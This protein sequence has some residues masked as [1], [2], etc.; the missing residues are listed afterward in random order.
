MPQMVEMG[1]PGA[2]MQH[3]PQPQQLGRDPSMYA[4]NGS[5]QVYV[6]GG[7][8]N[9]FQSGDFDLASRPGRYMPAQPSYMPE[10]PSYM[11]PMPQ[12]PTYMPNGA[13]PGIAAGGY[14]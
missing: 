3:M 12:R 2:R 7:S 8:S 10:Q 1:M 5:S 13:S 14:A 9:P 6:P 11:P 4:S